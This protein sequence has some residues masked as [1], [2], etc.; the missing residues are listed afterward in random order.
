MAKQVDSY[1]FLDYLTRNVVK[2]W[3]AKESAR[4]PPIAQY[5][6]SH[7]WLLPNLLA[8]SVPK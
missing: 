8:R 5:L 7:P 3:I 6:R 1:C 2:A 4:E